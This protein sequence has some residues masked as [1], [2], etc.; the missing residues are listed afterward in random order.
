MLARPREPL[1]RVKSSIG[2]DLR[3]A[4]H[5]RRQSCEYRR[6][7]ADAGA[8]QQALQSTGVD[9]DYLL[10]TAKIESNFNPSAQASISSAKGL[11]QFIDQTWLGTMKQDGHWDWA[12]TPTPLFAHPTEIMKSLIQPCAPR[13]AP[14]TSSPTYGQ[15]STSS[16]AK[17]PDRPARLGSHP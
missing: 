16:P 6:D 2:R 13:C 5:D 11:Y 14:S 7:T 10:A 15:T 17:K 1:R 8:I 9:F 12:V 4:Q 3:K